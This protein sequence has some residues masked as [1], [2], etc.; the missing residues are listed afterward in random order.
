MLNLS[1]TLFPIIFIEPASKKITFVVVKT[2]VMKHHSTSMKIEKK[3]KSVLHTRNIMFCLIISA[4]L[5]SGCSENNHI[6]QRME[7][8]NIVWTEQ[9]ASSFRSMPLS[10]TRGYGANIWVQNNALYGYLAGNESYDEN[11]DLLKLGC[12]R[13]ELSPNPFR[14][15][16]RFEQTLDPY[17]GRIL[18]KTESTDGNEAWLTLWYDQTSPDLYI[19]T[20]TGQETEC[21]LSLATWRTK[22]DTVAL[23]NWDLPTVSVVRPD[24][25]E[26]DP[27]TV[28]LY[29]QNDNRRLELTTILEKQK[30]TEYASLVPDVTRDLIFGCIAAGEDMVSVDTKES[31]DG[32]SWS[33]KAVSLQSN[34]KKKNRL[35]TIHCS[36][37]VQ[38]DA[39]AW[40]RQMKQSVGESLCRA[41]TSEQQSIKRWNEFWE[42][43]YVFINP[44]AGSKDEG[45]QVGRNYQLFRYMLACNEGGKLPLKF[46]GGIF[47]VE[48]VDQSLIKH[49]PA[50]DPW[51]P[52]K[53]ATPDYRKW[54]NFFMAQNQ[55]LVGWAGLVSGDRSLMEPSLK[56]YTDRLKL[57]EAR[58]RRYWNHG[59]ASFPECL[60][61]YGLPVQR[62]AAADGSMLYGHLNNH[63]SMQIEFAFMMIQY[64]RYS[65]IDIRNYLPFIE[66]VLRFYDE[67][68]RMEHKKRTG[69][70]LG[71]DGCLVL[72][73]MNSLEA[74]A[75]VTDPV[76][77]I[78]GMRKVCEEILR[79]KGKIPDDTRQYVE[80][81]SKIIPEIPYETRDGVTVIAPARQY[82]KFF[83]EWELPEMFTVWP[84]ATFGINNAEA[85][86]IAENTWEH[87]PEKRQNALSFWSWMCT[88]IYAACMGRE[89][90]ARRLII[91][92]MSDKNANADFPAFFGPGHDWIPDFNWGA[93]G[94]IALH[95]ML[96]NTAGDSTLLFSAWPK[97]WDV[98]YKLYL[99]KNKF[100]RGKYTKE[101]TSV[102]TDASD[103]HAFLIR[104][105]GNADAIPFRPEK[106]TQ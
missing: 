19:R 68:Y 94:M 101:K 75:D 92:K 18:V 46:N 44:D 100:I 57:A 30:M 21:R 72:Y 2:F 37:D 74:F 42:H 104:N 36:T 93:S 106:A 77:V 14:E 80:Q 48:P 78:A 49:L 96:V 20:E 67:H 9:S 15:G 33:G 47:T 25:L 29:H 91:E 71:E 10:G 40:I 82:E 76:E 53:K 52:D 83:N 28:M 60:S 12:F 23:D 8:Y 79:F 84:Y 35:I 61:P 27:A 13:L 86:R 51:W 88:P 62:I 103:E 7:A 50:Y 39:D 102:V 59:G 16:T 98:E 65:D 24:S 55:R 34:G 73:P 38:T 70:E 41:E 45:W 43:G 22:V 63:Y 11:G 5:F 97:D 105:P 17:N 56:Y 87:V 1:I 95:K 69:K 64:C 4:G 89:A 26:I 81:L 6:R 99:P 66:S 85:T 3:R 32:F 58:S 90:D 31:F 54:G